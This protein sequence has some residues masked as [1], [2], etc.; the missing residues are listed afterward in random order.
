[1][2]LR[3]GGFKCSYKILFDMYMCVCD[4][5]SNIYLHETDIALS[6]VS[7]SSCSITSWHLLLNI[8]HIVDGHTVVQL[9]LSIEPCFGK[10]RNKCVVVGDRKLSDVFVDTISIL[11]IDESCPRTFGVTYTLGSGSKN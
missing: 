8:F 4:T 11:C 5:Y 2:F 3:G 7:K 1:M 6:I 10:R 9:L